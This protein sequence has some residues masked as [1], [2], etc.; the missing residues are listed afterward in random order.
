MI[1]VQVGIM[2]RRN[3]KCYLFAD[4]QDILRDMHTMQHHSELAIIGTMIIVTRHDL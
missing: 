3:A 2:I 1:H 4:E